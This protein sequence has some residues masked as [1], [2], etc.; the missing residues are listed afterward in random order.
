[1]KKTQMKRHLTPTVPDTCLM[2]NYG[3]ALVMTRLSAQALVRPVAADTDIGIDLYC[4]TIVGA[5]PHLHFWVQV[6]AGKQC[7]V[8]SQKRYAS[9][10]FS[11]EKIRYWE[12]QPVPVFA[13]LVPTQWPPNEEPDIHI[14][15]ITTQAL[16]NPFSGKQKTHTLRSDDCWPAGSL[17]AVKNFGA[18]ELLVGDCGAGLYI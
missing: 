8:D 12:R 9:A 17:D 11:T 6:K 15:D 7:E 1:M 2:G 13:A 4:E 3:A 18:P 5:H 16:F 10:K 14:I